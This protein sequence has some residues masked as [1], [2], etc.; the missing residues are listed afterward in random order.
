ML[1]IENWSSNQNNSKNYKNYCS[2][3]CISNNPNIDKK[4]FSAHKRDQIQSNSSVKNYFS[5]N[6]GYYEWTSN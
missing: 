2:D 4:Y 6:S 1:C 3:N 5:W